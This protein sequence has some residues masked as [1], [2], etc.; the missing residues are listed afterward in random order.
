VCVVD[1]AGSVV[2]VGTPWKHV[3]IDRL[4]F[5]FCSVVERVCNW[6]GQVN[7]VLFFR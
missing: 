6:L 2:E 5:K 3:Y 7:A 4:S 1:V